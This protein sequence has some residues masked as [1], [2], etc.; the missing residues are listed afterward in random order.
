MH[1]LPVY[2]YMY[3]GLLLASFYQGISSFISL[4]TIL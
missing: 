1:K 4:S 2:L 3:T